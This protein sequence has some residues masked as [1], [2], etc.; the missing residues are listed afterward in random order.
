MALARLLPAM[1][2]ELDLS[3]A[4]ACR[5]RYMGAVAR[6]KWAGVPID[7]ET[8]SRLR[9][10][11]TSNQDR[12]IQ[13]V[14]SRFGMFDGRTFKAERWSSWLARRGLPRPRLESGELALDDDS[15]REMARAYPDVALM[16]ELRVSLSQLR[17][18][19]LA[20]GADGRSGRLL[21]PFRAKTGRNQPSKSLDC[22]GLSAPRVRRQGRDGVAIPLL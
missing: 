4:V 18:A 12:L 5:G 14:D 19:D 11:W 9:A 20:V 1:E 22:V 16:Q 8:I 21:S 13:E 15:F 3:R 10:G 17:L 7:M 6:M 2:P